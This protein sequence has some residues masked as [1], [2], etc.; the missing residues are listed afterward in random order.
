MSSKKSSLALGD[1]RGSALIVVMVLVIVAGGML[2]AMLTIH[3][4]RDKAEMAGEENIVRMYAAEAGLERA[5]LEVVS[6][7]GWLAANAGKSAATFTGGATAFTVNGA[8]VTVDIAQADANW[9]LMRSSAQARGHTTIIAVTSRNGTLFADYARFVSKGVLDIG[10]Y[11]TYGGKVHCNSNINVNGDYV[12]FQE[13][14]TAAGKVNYSN[15]KGVVFQKRCTPGVPE[16]P[17]PG[18]DQLRGLADSAPA[19]A[20]VYDWNDADFKTRFQTATGVL[21]ADDLVVSVAF[22]QN[23]MDV[24]STSGGKTMTESNL[25][26]PHNGTV[27]STGV[28][29]VGGNISRRLSVVSP[30]RIHIDGPVRY[31]DDSGQGQW[32]LQDKD[33]NPMPFDTGKNSWS[34]TGNWNGPDYKYVQAD[35]WPA[36]C[37]EVDG[38]RVQ[39][40]L[41]LVTAA[42]PD[43]KGATGAIYISGENDNREVH[44]AL[45]SSSDVVRPDVHGTKKNLYILGAI[46]TTGTNPV[47]SYFSYRCYAYDPYLRGHPPPGFPGGDAAAFRNWHIIELGR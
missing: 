40:A 6:D 30:N 16:I 15:R 9:Y 8:T 3:M 18:Y 42:D 28:T 10:D 7:S 4:A 13:D 26:V 47:S 33:G 2:A 17:L 22:K 31:T 23:K 46:I 20:K 11:A 24:V 29:R 43:I 37:P 39:P 32:Q 25:D 45:F 41:G 14:V 12:V 34:M 44:A 5:K 19:G 21:P 27:Y 36:R 38:Q 1:R 35:D